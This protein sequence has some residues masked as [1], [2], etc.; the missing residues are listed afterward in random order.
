MSLTPRSTLFQLHR[1]GY[2]NWWKKP[3]K[4]T[5]LSQVTDTFDHIMLN[6]DHLDINGVRTPNYHTIT[7]RTAPIF[8]LL[9]I[10]MIISETI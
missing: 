7:T 10:T 9:V 4:T 5:D 2:F 8:S 6:R 3:E 1:G